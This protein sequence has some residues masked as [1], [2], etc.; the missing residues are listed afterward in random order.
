MYYRWP[1]VCVNPVRAYAGCLILGGWYTALALYIVQTWKQIVY[2]ELFF[3]PQDLASWKK[4]HLKMVCSNMLFSPVSPTPKRMMKPICFDAFQWW[5]AQPA[6]TGM[7]A[8]GGRCARGFQPGSECCICQV[9]HFAWDQVGKGRGKHQRW[10]ISARKWWYF[11]GK[12]G[13]WSKR[14]KS[15]HQQKWI[16]AN[17]HFCGLLGATGGCSP[18]IPH[19]VF[20]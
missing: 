11:Q 18:Y 1:Q 4:A 8:I 3:P 13:V 19:A 10:A 17:Y 14:Q 9:A 15:I 2:Q 20:L 5:V 16:F 12:N 7:L 6:V